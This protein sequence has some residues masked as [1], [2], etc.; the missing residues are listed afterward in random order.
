VRPEGGVGVVLPRRNRRCS[1]SGTADSDEQIAC[2]SGGSEREK[3]GEGRGEGGLLIG[4]DG[5][6]SYA[7]N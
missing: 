5:E 3:E 6:S 1:L 7:R 2:P 4:T